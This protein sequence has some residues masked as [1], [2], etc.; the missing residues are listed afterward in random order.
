MPESDPHPTRHGWAERVIKTVGY[1]TPELCAAAAAGA[2]A[3]TWSPWWW[4]LSAALALRV[5]LT[6]LW[7]RARAHWAA[8]RAAGHGERG[9]GLPKIGSS[10]T[11][12]KRRG[13][14]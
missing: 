5:T 6:P 11:A 14:A 2:A 7:R 13:V 3:V 12:R 10:S 8:R 4:T 9:D 1:W